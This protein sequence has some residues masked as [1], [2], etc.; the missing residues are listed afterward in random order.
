MSIIKIPQYLNLYEQRFPLYILKDSNFPPFGVTT[1][2]WPHTEYVRR[3]L[4]VIR[5]KPESRDNDDNPFYTR[6]MIHIVLYPHVN[7][8]GKRDFSYI[9]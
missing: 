6:R 4:L 7:H 2:P 1:H 5:C 3:S 8:T 9:V